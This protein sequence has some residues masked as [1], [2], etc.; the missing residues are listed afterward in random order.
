MKKT[1]LLFIAALVI[2][3][4]IDFIWPFT[5]ERKDGDVFEQGLNTAEMQIYQDPDLGFMVRYPSF[6]AI[7]PD[8]LDEY[9]SYVRISYDN[10]RI[11]VVLECY[12]LHNNGQSLKSGMDSLA[13]VLNAT[14]RKL[15]SDYFILSGPQYENNSCID[16]YSYYSRFVSRG[17]LWFVYTMVYPNRYRDHLSRLFKEIDEWQVFEDQRIG[18]SRADSFILDA[19][20]KGYKKKRTVYNSLS[21][22]RAVVSLRA[23]AAFPL[24]L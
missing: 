1:A 14:D 16:D 10:E 2:M 8:S 12:V 22:A 24:F 20:R 13:K 19:I 4:N 9:K 6:F 17:K 5:S 18:I 3:V 15:G 7:Q 21:L 11:N 23:D